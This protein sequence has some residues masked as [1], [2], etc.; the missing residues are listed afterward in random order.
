MIMAV[1]RKREEFAIISIGNLPNTVN[2][3]KD[4]VDSFDIQA[5][6]NTKI[7]TSQIQEWNVKEPSLKTIIN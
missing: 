6:L 1:S 3:I 2:A 7:H 5:K 4:N